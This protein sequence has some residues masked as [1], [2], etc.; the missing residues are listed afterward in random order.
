MNDKNDKICEL[1][2]FYKT[3][4]IS[5]HLNL[6]YGKWLNGKIISISETKDRFV[7]QEDKFG[8]MLVFFDRLDQTNPIEPK[9]DGEK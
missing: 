8:E 4:N 1:L 9:K 3:K 7:F 2:E 6:E 5:V